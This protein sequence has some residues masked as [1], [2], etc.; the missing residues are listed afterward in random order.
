LSLP[1]LEH[2]WQ[3]ASVSL[4]RLADNKKTLTLTEEVL[5]K[6]NQR[7]RFFFEGYG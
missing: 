7:W 6:V 1:D 2:F 4:N 5:G 3:Q